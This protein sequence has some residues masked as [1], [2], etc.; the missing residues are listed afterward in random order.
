MQLLHAWGEY[1]FVR[2]H[3]LLTLD[4]EGAKLLRVKLAV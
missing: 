1:E 3:T 4:L 2:L